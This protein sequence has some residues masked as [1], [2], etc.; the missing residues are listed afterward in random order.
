W[1]KE[2]IFDLSN[3][4]SYSEVQFRFVIKKGNV[5]GTQISYGWVLDNFELMG[6]VYE[7]K[8]PVV[9]FLTNFTDTVYNTGPY[10]IQAKVAKRTAI[11]LETPKLVYTASHPST[12]TVTDTLTMTAV[13]GDSIWEATIPQYIFGTTISYSVRGEDTVGNYATAHDGFYSVRSS[14]GIATGY[15]YYQGQD[16]V[17]VTSNNLALIYHVGYT[18]SLSRSLYLASEINPNNTNLFI[19]ELAWYLRAGSTNAGSVNVTRGLK[20]WMLATNDVS[21]TNVLM[22][23]TQS[24]ATLVYVGNTQSV[25]GWNAISLTQPFSLP[26]GKNL[27][28]FFEG[29]GGT[30]SSS[31][32]Y[33]AGHSQSNRCTY[34]YSGS[35]TLSSMVPIMRFGLGAPIMDSNSVALKSIDNPTSSGTLANQLQPVK[36]TFKNK[37][38]ANLT[39]AVF[40]WS[41]NGVMQ[42]TVLWTGNLPDDFNDTVTLG[43][44][45]Q[46]AGEYDTITAWVNMP[47][48][49]IDTN[50]F[51][52]TLHVIS[53]GCDAQLSGTY[54]VGEDED[55]ETVADFVNIAKLCNPVGDISL[56]I[57]SGIYAENWDL[58]S[59]G[60]IMGNYILTITSEAHNA[61]SVIIKPASGVALKL[62][63]NKNL[64]I[65]NITFDCSS[66]T[67]YTVQFTAGCE[68]VLIRDCKILSSTTATASSSTAIYK[69]SSTGIL[70][71]VQFINNYI[72][73]GY[74]GFYLYGGT[75]TGAF[76]QDLVVDSNIIIDQY[77]YG[78]YFYYN[79]FKS[80]SYNKIYSR[81]A[82]TSATWYGLRTYYG[83]FDIF[84]ANSI[85][86]RSTA[87]TQPY[88]LYAYYTNDARYGNKPATPALFTNNE[89][90]VYTS[91]T[92][93]AIYFYYSTINFYHNSVL[94]RGTSAGRGLYLG[95]V[96]NSYY[97]IQG[98]NI[99]NLSSSGY[100]IY[101]SSAPSSLYFNFANNNLYA[102]TYTAYAGG[103]ISGL[104]GWRGLFP[105]DVNTV[106]AA[107]SYVDNTQG[108][109]LSDY[110][111]FAMRRMA[112]VATDIND[113]ARAFTTAMGCYKG[114]DPRGVDA[115][116]NSITELQSGVVVNL[117]DSVK[118][119]L[120]NGG[121]TT[122]TSAT[123]NWS[124]NGVNQAPVTWTGSLATEQSVM[125]TLGAITYV[126]KTNAVKAWISSVGS[127]TDE[128]LHND[129]IETSSYA[130]T[131][132]LAGTYTV[133]TATSD[134]PTLD[135]ALESLTYCGLTGAVT[136]KL[137]GG[138]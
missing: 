18:T 66:I 53:Y 27:Y 121:S 4:V 88:G 131:S 120:L 35:W 99:V 3:D 86:Q 125:V 126:A 84:N 28:V 113:S 75:G 106:S 52:D 34:N 117:T 31:Y 127:L 64:T 21:T 33:W 47:N 50:T 129:T 7:L 41:L 111:P 92:Y 2:E 78:T 73:G 23:P 71:N 115:I 89:V 56:E 20:V 30:T 102:P 134:F 90:N 91:S 59:I 128:D 123:I 40:G 93:Y 9:E 103:N 97:D 107:P 100:P 13:K 51:D 83:E 101:F 15:T 60:N 17:G 135:E 76:G 112:G 85:I 54:T 1:W 16:T 65:K 46:R 24:G 108:L 105:N 70:K 118:V 44:Y 80:C 5:T 8:A 48:N 26:A 81:T 124:I 82:N 122:I 116:L 77:Y 58:S 130:C 11:G 96:A 6:S 138:N 110:T 36:V 109:N 38:F 87:I 61:D 132:A 63:N 62:G 42:D 72:S 69:A 55:F 10:T 133:G 57:K 79:H 43:Y 67:A 37:G 19:S 68:D 137:A 136:M 45:T 119:E 39:S 94:V 114:F 29:T 25:V 74:Y 14:S 22:D 98:N 12:A 104:S 49:V 95:N 32:I